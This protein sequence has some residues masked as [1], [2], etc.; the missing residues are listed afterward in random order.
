M[1]NFNLTNYLS[2]NRLTEAIEL[3]R[4]Y[5]ED[6]DEVAQ[7][8]A[9]HFTKTDNLDLIYSIK[10][11]SLKISPKGAYFD[12]NTE[13]GPNTPGEDFKDENGF[14]I[15]N[16]LGDYA[17]GSFVIKS[18]EGLDEDFFVIRNMANRNA[19]V[20][21]VNPEGEVTFTTETEINEDVEYSVNDFPIGADVSIGDE[22]WKVVKPGTRGEKIFMAPF[23]AEAKRRYISIAIEF[24][25]NWLNANI[26]NISK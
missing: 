21:M 4:L 26:T 12:L 13:A 8:V 3:T 5:P 10:P 9:D 11:G 19:K 16:Y 6:P 1:S 14:G 18:E 23:N 17:G 24:D 2:K 15:E 22:V 25:L 20:G 7:K